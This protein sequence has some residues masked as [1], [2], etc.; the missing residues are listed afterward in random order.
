MLTFIKCLLG[1]KY[2]H[3]NQNS[4][5]YA[6]FQLH[7]PFLP[8]E[9]GM[10]PAMETKHQGSSCEGVGVGRLG[11]PSLPSQQPL[12]FDHKTW[13]ESTVSFTWIRLLEE[14]LFP[15]FSCKSWRPGR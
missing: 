1:T 7:A 3:K 5:L 13:I 8:P 14:I 11:S 15:L 6:F 9:S 2:F 10:N 12:W 4:N